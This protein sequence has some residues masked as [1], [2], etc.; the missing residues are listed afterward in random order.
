VGK[1]GKNSQTAEQ[2]EKQ[3]KKGRGIKYGER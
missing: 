3:K 1:K 2:P